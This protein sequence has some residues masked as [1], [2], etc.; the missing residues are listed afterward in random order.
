MMPPSQPSDSNAHSNPKLPFPLETSGM[1][2]PDEMAQLAPLAKK[3]LDDPVAL[4]RLGDRV[5]EL[6]S[7]DLK[8]QR[9]RRQ[10]YGR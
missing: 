8:V 1:L 5:F 7:Q 4:M 3:I 2:N 6:L 9:E 10:G